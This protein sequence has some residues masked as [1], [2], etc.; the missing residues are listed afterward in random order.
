MPPAS[1]AILLLSLA[2][3]AS[4]AAPAAL[5]IPHWT[6][7]RPNASLPFA[8]YARLPTS[9]NAG[10]Y[11]GSEAG[12]WYNHAAMITYHR[13]MGIVTSW[14]NAPESE[15]T[16]G[17]RVLFSRSQDG[18]HWTTAAV[19]FPNISTTSTPAALFAGPFAEIAGHLYATATP[20]I[21]TKS[22][23]DAQGAQWCLWP[24]GLDPEL[25]CL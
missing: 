7:P 1:H 8:G 2:A 4:A 18:A 21:T 20:G 17:Q 14:K 5:P 11:L 16:P 3:A 6:A 12:G 24:D 19:L 23:G 22:R 25:Q 9:F 13:A 15:D 10:I